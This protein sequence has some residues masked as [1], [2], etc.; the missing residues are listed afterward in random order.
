MRMKEETARYFENS[1][2]LCRIPDI[3]AGF[4]PQGLDEVAG[5]IL[6]TGYMGNGKTSPIYVVSRETGEAK[7]IL[8]QTEEGKPFTGHAGGLSVFGDCVYI[9]GSTGGFVY[10]YSLEQILSASDGSAIGAVRKITLK[11]EEDAIRVSF[12]GTDGMHLYAGEFHKDPIFYTHRSHRVSTD[13]GIQ[14][15]YLFGFTVGDAGE[16]QPSL[17]YSIPDNVQGACFAAGK[18]YLSQTDGLLRA[19][20]LTYD[21]SKIPQSGTKRVLGKEIPLYILT[22][23]NAQK[24]TRIPPMSEEILASDGHLHIL[25]ESASNRY[26]IGKKLGL[27]KVGSTPLTFFE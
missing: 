15:A 18:L 17:V 5:Q 11:N 27:D 21:L 12:T 9:A 6:I 13:T 10:A 7:K 16:A 22:T 1:T 19:R 25:Y 2:A 24:A 20:I 3:D 26:R 4:I 23:D 14:K 8:M